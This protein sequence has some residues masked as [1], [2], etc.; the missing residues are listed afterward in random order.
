MK[1][2]YTLVNLTYIFT[3]FLMEYSFSNFFLDHTDMEQIHGTFCSDVIELVKNVLAETTASQMAGSKGGPGGR[4]GAPPLPTKKRLSQR[5]PTRNEQAE[6]SG[7]DP[8]IYQ[9]QLE[10]LSAVGT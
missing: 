7:I 2:I 3:C 1:Y 8:E 10:A 6:A 9:K 4:R 5:L